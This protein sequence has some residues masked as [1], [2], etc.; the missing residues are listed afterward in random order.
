[1][2]HGLA[3]PPHQSRNAWL[4][5]WRGMPQLKL[6]CCYYPEHWT[7]SSGAEAAQRMRQMGLSLGAHREF[8]VGAGLRTGAG[9]LMTGMAT[10]ARLIRLAGGGP[11]GWILGT[12]HHPLR[13][14][15]CSI[16][17]ADMVAI[18]ENG[19]P[20]GFGSRRHYCFSHEV[21]RGELPADR[22]RAGDTLRQ[23]PRHRDMADRQRIGLLMD[24]VLRLSS[25]L[26]LPF[27]Q[28]AGERVTGRGRSD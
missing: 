13:P 22:H 6:G 9:P 17:M 15:G 5:R 1:M 24:T 18:D 23:P 4:S 21:Y 2:T 20:R 19:R 27:P 8:R 26:P 12:N 11:Q 7:G 25:R 28:L 10:I 3:L 16:R 14:N